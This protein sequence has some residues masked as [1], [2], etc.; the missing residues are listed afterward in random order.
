MRKT[1][2]FFNK[3]FLKLLYPTFIRPHLEFA[4]SAWNRMSKSDIK[5]VQRRAAGM[6]LETIF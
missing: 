4:T 2:R 3:E 1:F 6:V 5:S